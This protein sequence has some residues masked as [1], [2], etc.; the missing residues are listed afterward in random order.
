VTPVGRVAVQAREA[1]GAAAAAPSDGDWLPLGVFIVT[2]EKGQTTSDKI[3]QLS[4]NKEGEIFVVCEFPEEGEYVF[5]SSAYG[6][7]AGP[8]PPRMA[9]R[10]DGRDVKTVDVTAEGAPAIH[11]A[12]VTI[13]SGKRRISVAY[14]N[15]YVNMDDPDP[16]KRVRWGDQTFEE[17][18]VGFISFDV[19][20]TQA[21]GPG[22][23]A[24]R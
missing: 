13:P 19:D 6:Q 11:E 16:K 18:M 8:E 20:A 23:G 14:L 2:T 10:V 22:N 12:R 17:M 5:R 3:V 15:N 4:L 7:Q 9:F 1:G 24:P 21:K